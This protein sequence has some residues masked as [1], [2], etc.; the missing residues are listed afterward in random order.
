V[1]RVKILVINAGSTSVKYDVYDMDSEDLLAHG[2]IERVDATGYAAAFR[3]LLDRLGPLCAE[4]AAVGHRVVHG[5]D[6]LIAPVRIDATVEAVIEECAELA[7]LHNPVNLL[8]IRAAREKL[9][10]IPHV[11]VFD[12]AFHAHMPEHAFM[13]GLPR[14]L[15][16]A[17]GIRRYGFHGPSHQYMAACAAEYL[18]TDPRRLRLVTCHLGGGASVS[19][20]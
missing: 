13:Y 3:A 18:A 7:P 2:T 10:G 12:T 14:D 20:T 17:H 6:R 16:L 11:A 9:P 1:K 15:Y 8:G 4:L 19:A 5:G